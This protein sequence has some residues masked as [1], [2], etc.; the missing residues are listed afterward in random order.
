MKKTDQTLW[1]VFFASSLLCIPVSSYAGDVSSTSCMGSSAKVLNKNAEPYKVAISQAAKRYDVSP[2]LIKAVIASGSCFNAVQVSPKG[3]VG[4]M[5]LR[6]DTAKR[7][8]ALEVLNPEANIDAGTRYLSYL[9]KRYQGSLAEVFAAY[10]SDGGR[11]GEEVAKQVPLSDIRDSVNQLLSTLLKLENNK[12]TNRQALALLKTWGKEEKAYFSALSELPKPDEKAA[13]TWFQSRVASVHYPRTPEARGCG[14]FSVKTLQGKAAPYE[15]IIQ[16]AAK[17]YSVNPAL[18]KSVIAAESCYREMVVSYKGASGLMQLM[19]ETADE[20]GVMDIFDPSENINAGTR[21]L[22]WLLKRYDGSPTHA[23]AAYNAGAGRIEQGKP[24]TVAFTETRGYIKTVLTNLTKLE[25][26]KNSIANAQLLL[27]DWQQAELAYQAALRGETLAV[28][29]PPAEAEI[30]GTGTLMNGQVLNQ[31]VTAGMALP[32]ESELLAK[33]LVFQRNEKTSLA[34]AQVAEQPDPN[35]H[36][37]S[38]INQDIVRV[39]RISATTIE[40]PAVAPAEPLVTE[41]PALIVEEPAPAPV[42]PEPEIQ[43]NGL[44]SCASLPSSVI[45][46]TA[47]RGSGRY[48]AFFYFPQAGDTIELVASKLGIHSQDLLSLNHIR[49]D[50]VLIPG[51]DL[52]VAEC[53]RP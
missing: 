46:Q 25:Q 52:K 3:S 27:A 9:L 10:V 29:E 12:K 14:G 13:K 53:A 15:K 17:R 42:V 33:D 43:Q 16:S 6:A 51:R 19:P 2:S 18:V 37:I 1:A 36:L 49:L 7:F 39:K 28:T 26:G 8:G 30:E 45:A 47:E 4:L 23:I 44:I 24:V 48:G 21:Y 32:T 50:T 40:E 41:A 22:S 38:S 20:L 34:S 31:G 5:Q 11:V 35:V